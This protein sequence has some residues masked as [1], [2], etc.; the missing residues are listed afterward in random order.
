[1]DDDNP[2]YIYILYIY[3]YTYIYICIIIII[4]IIYINTYCI[5]LCICICSTIYIHNTL[6]GI[7][8]YNHQPKLLNTPHMMPVTESWTELQSLDSSSRCPRKLKPI[9]CFFF[10]SCIVTIYHFLKNKNDLIVYV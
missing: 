3:I 7:I 5:I 8:P 4:T 9:N 10:Y 6:E 2:Q 1:M